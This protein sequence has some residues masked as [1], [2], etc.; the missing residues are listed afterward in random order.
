MKA[1]NKG[2]VVLGVGL[3]GF[4]LAKSLKFKSEFVDT[5]TYIEI[6]DLLEKIQGFDI[7]TLEN[8]A[9]RVSSE[10]Y[11]VIENLIS[12]YNN[13]Y[14]NFTENKSEIEDLNNQLLDISNQ[15]ENVNQLPEISQ[16]DKYIKDRNDKKRIL[17]RE[18]SAKNAEYQKVRN[19]WLEVESKRAYYQDN[20]FETSTNLFT[21]IEWNNLAEKSENLQIEMYSLENEA[22]NL[23][24]DYDYWDNYH[25]QT[26]A[27]KETWISN[28]ITPLIQQ[29]AAIESSLNTWKIAYQ[30]VFNEMSDLEHQIEQLVQNENGN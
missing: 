26:I 29:K 8:I 14:I 27:E 22:I 9:E 16:F 7:S 13:K 19:E 17:W 20:W 28:N 10:T 5:N 12:E 25:N 4:L 30:A 1:K 11:S 18:Y 3:G 2:L 6:K 24:S 15:I 23:K 21:L